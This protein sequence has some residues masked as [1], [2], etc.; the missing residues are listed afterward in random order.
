MPTCVCVSAFG[1]PAEHSRKSVARLAGEPVD[2]ACMSRP[3]V[4]AVFIIGFTSACSPDKGFGNTEDVSADEYG[5]A[6]PL[7]TATAKV[8]CS[9][10][11]RLSVTVEGTTYV[12][13]PD[14]S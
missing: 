9:E 11:G 5:A 12:L 3:I 14:Q 1:P 4:V 6:W 13:E 10:V 8:G 2:D 7:T